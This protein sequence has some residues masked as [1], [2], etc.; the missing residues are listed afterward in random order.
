M[1]L[2]DVSIFIESF[3]PVVYLSKD[4]KPNTIYF[5]QIVTFY[6]NHIEE[7][8][9]NFVYFTGRGCCANRGWRDGLGSYNT[10]NAK[11]IPNSL[12]PSNASRTPL[13]A[14]YEKIVGCTCTS[15]RTPICLASLIR[16]CLI[17]TVMHFLMP[18]RRH[19]PF[20]KRHHIR[21]R[22]IG[23]FAMRLELK[24]KH[25]RST[26]GPPPPPKSFC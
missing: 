24:K 3:C 15:V 16:H 8:P 14:K 18:P 7:P 9:I 22:V 21:S 6:I 10:Q 2:L 17:C 13:L 25:S 1:Q 5:G 20:H 26:I 19:V 12:S 23:S 4:K 11:L